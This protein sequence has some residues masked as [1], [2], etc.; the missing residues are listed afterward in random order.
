MAV[1]SIEIYRMAGRQLTHLGGYRIAAGAQQQMEMIGDRRPGKATGF[2][3]FQDL[4]QPID[5]IVTIL[6]IFENFSTLDTANN[7]MVQGSGGVYPRLS[8]HAR[9]LTLLVLERQVY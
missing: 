2:R 1:S 3:L 9:I 5:K 4:A 6:I 8:G 7:N